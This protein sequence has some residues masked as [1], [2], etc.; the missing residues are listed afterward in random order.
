MAGHVRPLWGD[1]GAGGEFYGEVTAVVGG[2]VGVENDFSGSGW[3]G[4]QDEWVADFEDVAAGC[5]I[6]GE[7]NIL[8]YSF[9]GHLPED[10]P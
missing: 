9:V 2:D 8:H 6:V 10:T 3:N 7:E 1:L 5:P 4:G